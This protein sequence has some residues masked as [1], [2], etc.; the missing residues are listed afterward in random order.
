MF[1]IGKTKYKPLGKGASKKQ[2]QE[3]MRIWLIFTVIYVI[4]IGIL[5][6]TADTYYPDPIPIGL[7]LY[8]DLATTIIYAGFAIWGLITV[9][10]LKIKL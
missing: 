6:G 1:T 9:M 2:K 8:M 10:F 7:G 3:Y 5:Y 4:V